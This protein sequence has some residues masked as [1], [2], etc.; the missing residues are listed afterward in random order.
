MNIITI[1]TDTCSKC[2]TCTN[3]IL[4]IPYNGV[5][6]LLPAV[7]MRKLYI[8]VQGHKLDVHRNG[9]LNN[10][11]LALL[12]YQQHFPILHQSLYSSTYTNEQ[13]HKYNLI[14]LKHQRLQ[15]VK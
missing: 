4:T 1:T 13:I 8:A 14:I 7:Q 10:L 12:N 5:N 15:H 11:S 6:V 9:N 2:L 3:I